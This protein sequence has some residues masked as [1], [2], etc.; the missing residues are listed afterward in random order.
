MGLQDASVPK[1]RT[2]RPGKGRVLG[3][4]PLAVVV[5]PGVRAVPKS[6]RSTWPRTH[7]SSHPGDNTYQ[8]HISPLRTLLESLP[9]LCVKH[10]FRICPVGTWHR[11]SE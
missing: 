9:M 6:T 8:W 2:M 1:V 10:T 4:A 7:N 11:S 3:P 5:V